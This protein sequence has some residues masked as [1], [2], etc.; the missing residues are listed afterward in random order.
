[1]TRE[2][3]QAEAKPMHTPGP[4]ARAALREASHE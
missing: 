2:H 1:M 4:C 3:A